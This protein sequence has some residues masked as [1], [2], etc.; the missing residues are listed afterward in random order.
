MLLAEAG[1]PGRPCVIVCAGVHGDEPAGPAALL[2]LLEDGLLDDRFSY[3]LFPCTNPTGLLAGSRE[4]AEGRD[5]NRSFG[6]GGLTPESKAIIIA[7]RDRRFVLALDLHEDPQ[8]VG[9]YCYEPAGQTPIGP[10]VICAVDAAAL[11]VATFTPGFDLGYPHDAE[12]LRRLERGRV[13]A[14]FEEESKLPAG[15]PFSLYISKKAARRVLTL[16]SPGTLSWIDRIATLRVAVVAA[17]A[18]LVAK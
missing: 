10:A 3:R 5:V 6:R 9:F 1:D 12:H 18:A 4:N 16:E 17:I 11:P 2:S 15:L 7:N 8:A 14:D 13:V